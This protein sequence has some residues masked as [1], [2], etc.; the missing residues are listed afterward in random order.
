M[1]GFVQEAWAN[2]YLMVVISRER[3]YVRW[4]DRLFKPKLDMA[5]LVSSRMIWP[6]E[7]RPGGTF[8]ASCG[9]QRYQSDAWNDDCTGSC[10]YGRGLQWSEGM[11]W[12]TRCDSPRRED[13]SLSH[14]HSSGYTDND[15][16]RFFIEKA[17]H[18]DRHTQLVLDGR[19]LLDGDGISIVVQSIF[20][21][22]WM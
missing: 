5:R 19:D 7:A 6:D 8:D 9:H 14:G 17:E 3:T 11:S 20:W 15:Y 21:K 4:G 10:W 1:L 12:S 16:P 18:V 22:R 2:D 13:R